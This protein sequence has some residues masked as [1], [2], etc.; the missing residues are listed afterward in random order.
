MNIIERGREFVQK[1][2]EL[3]RR[4]AWDWRHCSRC[5]GTWTC[6]YGG[7]FRY[8]WTL[9]GRQRVRIQRHWCYACSKVYN[10]EQAWLVA[11]SWYA[12]EVHR[13]AVDQWVHGGSSLR[14]VTEF[15]RSLLGR[16][17]R[18]WLWHVEEGKAKEPGACCLHHSTIHRWLDRAGQKAQESVA[19]QLEGLTCS[20][21]MG[22]DGLWARLRGGGK[23]V[24]LT[25][26]DSVT[27]LLWG[28]VVVAEEESAASWRA[29]FEQAQAMGLSWETLN[30]L[31]S[32]GAQG[33][34]SYLREAF[35]WVHHQRCVW[36]LWR[37]LAA[38]LAKSVAQAAQGLAADLAK[39]TQRAVR[40]ELTALL[41][42][43][44]DAPSCEQAEVALAQL[45]AHPYGATL[46]QKLNAQ[47]DRLLFALLPCHQGLLRIA[48]EWLWRSFRLRLSR[49]RNHGS[50]ERLQR[51]T[52]LWKVYHDFT[53]AQR[54]SER[55]RH[56]K[57]PG[58]SPLEVAGGA[59]GE[60]SYLDALEV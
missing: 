50:E 23:R 20:G 37:S 59:P 45:K 38:D 12:Q 40:K 51:A 41:H 28:M 29:L 17:E 18:W 21:Q 32:D 54:R 3:A 2:R 56:Y 46:A 6:K 19:G 24:V 15:L 44:I 35:S 7:R 36:H 31:T 47:L 53:P 11:G 39:T 42:A 13:Y 25:L 4:S 5:G 57:H 43:V 14:R 8:P 34:L 52:L 9:A 22:T 16:Q 27:G 60:I 55:K 33:L 58:Q 26:V 10:E 48:P 49:G 30:G 1:V